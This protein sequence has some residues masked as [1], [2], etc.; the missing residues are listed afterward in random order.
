MIIT[1]ELFTSEISRLSIQ[2]KNWVIGLSGGADSLCL[3]LLASEYLI[4]NTGYLRACIVDHKLRPES[5]T[6][7][8]PTI[9][10]L[11]KH[12]I[13]Y[14]VLVWEH[15][16]ITGS[17]EQKARAARYDLLYQYCKETNSEVLMTAHHSLDQWETFFMRLSRGSSLKGL[18]AIKPFSKFK[19]IHL[20]RPLLR[21]SPWDIR[22]T[23]RDRFGIDEYVKDPSNDLEKFERVRW[24]KAYQSLSN[25]YGLNLENITKTV[26]RLQSSNECLDEI[27]QNI[28]DDIFDGIY[29]NIKKFQNLHMEIRIRILNMIINSLSDKG[30][31]IVSYSL[32]QKVSLDIC[33]KDFS[34][35]NLSGLVFRRDRTKNVKVFKESRKIPNF[36]NLS[37]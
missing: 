26:E 4:E 6:E 14:K 9:E 16:E 30:L 1:K 18:S 37:E 32:L 21:F 22:E 29:I 15:S 35:T 12:S 25:D 28:L 27:A 13:D 20:A 17:I 19:D 3:T 5:S 2:G 31:H 8:L 36:S 34:A 7:I 10:I 11:K 24:R 23:L 33:R